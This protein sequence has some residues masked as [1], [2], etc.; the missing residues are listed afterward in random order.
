[1]SGRKRTTITIMESEY[2][3]L[4]AQERRLRQIR[5]ALPEVEAAISEV[6][7]EMASGLEQMQQRQRSL[8]QALQQVSAE[9]R[10]IEAET[11]RR[12]QEHQQRMQEALQD[13]RREMHTL[14]EEQGRR[15]QEML[16]EERRTRERQMARL[17]E[18]LDA[19][20]ADTRRKI[21]IARTW[22]EGA[23]A[24]RDFI[25]GHYRHQLF[26][27][28]ALERLE[29]DFEQAR[30]NLEQGIPE[31]ALAQAQRVY[32][33]LSDLRLELERLEA[34]W[35]L[36]KSTAL[37]S[38]QEI[39]ALAQAHRTSKAV[40]LE[41]KELDLAIEVDWWTGGRL[42][43]LE[44]ELKSLIYRLQSEKEFISLEELRNVVEQ[45]V[46]SF[47][48]RLEE[49]VKDARLAVLGS[50]LRINIADLVVQ[51][52]R[53]QGF[54]LQEATY[55]GEDMR[56]GYYVRVRHLDGGEVVVAVTPREGRPLEN[57]MEVH[58][59]DVEQRSERELQRR[60]METAQALQARGL[61]V[62]GPSKVSDRPDFTLR[63][64]ERI[65]QR[66]LKR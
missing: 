49:I 51:A 56:G 57:E 45:Q 66:Q 16:A 18:Q 5:E 62:Q 50:Q 4:L 23:K 22:I 29:R 12:L 54:E 3:R 46:P 39:L 8:Q 17:Q 30:K 11:A 19:L 36:W 43:A 40:D 13:V 61:Q 10:D 52:L 9:I 53:E 34:E 47:R 2:Q 64:L 31:A 44:K 48:Q 55:E 33:D 38:A 6:R 14:I 41:G 59:F 63:D 20:A 65:R 60:A 27:P 1:M 32:H 26:R 28:G 7:R 15:F 25:D 21:E 42:S 24:L 35:H 58:S 37:A